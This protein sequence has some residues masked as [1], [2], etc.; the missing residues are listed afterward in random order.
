MKNEL[1][2]TVLK[3]LKS[4]KSK[5]CGCEDM[6]E[7]IQSS[8][9]SI[10]TQTNR[11]Q[12]PGANMRNKCG[13]FT[14]GSELH[15]QCI[16]DVMNQGLQEVYKAAIHETVSKRIITG[17]EDVSEDVK[18]AEL[19][20][21]VKDLHGLI[22]SYKS[23]DDKKKAKEE[24]EEENG[25][26][27]EQMA[28]PTMVDPSFFK[29]DPNIVRRP[30]TGMASA[31]IIDPTQRDYKVLQDRQKKIA[32]SQAASAALNKPFE[33]LKKRDPI[34]AA[35]GPDALM[36]TAGIPLVKGVR[37]VTTAVRG[38]PK[39]T[40]RLVRDELG[41]VKVPGKGNQPVKSSTLT[42]EP[43]TQPKSP[44]V[45]AAAKKAQSVAAR[46]IDAAE[47]LATDA[48]V[49]VRKITPGPAGAKVRAATKTTAKEVGRGLKGAY[50]SFYGPID[51]VPFRKQLS[52]L[53]KGLVSPKKDNLGAAAPLTRELKTQIKNNPELGSIKQKIYRSQIRPMMKAIGAGE[54]LGA[55]GSLGNVAAQR[56]A[57]RLGIG[58]MFTSDDGSAR[59]I[60]PNIGVITRTFK[61][62]QSGKFSPKKLYDRSAER[63]KTASKFGLPGVSVAL[64]LVPATKAV[65]DFSTDVLMGRSGSEG[66]SDVLSREVKKGAKQLDQGLTDKFTGKAPTPEAPEPEAP[67]PETPKSTRRIFDS[68][69]MRELLKQRGIEATPAVMKDAERQFYEMNEA[70]QETTDLFDYE[71][72]DRI[73]KLG[74]GSEDEL[75]GS[76]FLGALMKAVDDY[77]KK[78]NLDFGNMLSKEKVAPFRRSKKSLSQVTKEY[79]KNV[80]KQIANYKTPSYVTTRSKVMNPS[81]FN[82]PGRRN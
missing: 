13:K 47:K 25:D 55:A 40:S 14:E 41:A 7:S 48:A 15:Q 17:Q 10:K 49:A 23:I 76:K 68:N 70:P 42:A 3:E 44:F 31:S 71:E 4:K 34:A 21:G 45:A 1:L 22:A 64:G 37:A 12:H 51:M 60:F 35:V 62:A 75:F 56:S 72:L 5:S 79:I 38:T 16:Y 80:D 50:R 82:K 53:T 74:A 24:D 57:E 32:A 36:S 59:E 77:S 58:D 33:E 52:R 28:P 20:R 39:T 27:N 65:K 29:I 66:M 81:R 63:V 69:K 6:E 78:Q 19:I 61:D 2:S 26:M 30:K 18:V 8:A 43:K 46:S 11:F 54:A 73:S 9:K 67:E